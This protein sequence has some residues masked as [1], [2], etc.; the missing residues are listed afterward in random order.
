MSDTGSRTYVS[1]RYRLR[2]KRK[3]YQFLRQVAGANRYLWNAA[4][5]NIQKEYEEKGTSPISFYDLSKWYAEHKHTEASWLAEYPVRLMRPGLKGVSTAFKEFFK[6]TRQHPKFKKKGKARKSFAVNVSRGDQFKEGYFRLKRG[7]HVKMMAYDRLRR[8]SNPK[9]KTARIFEERGKWYMTVLYEVD[10]IERETDTV[11]IGVDRNVG[12]VADSTGDIHY[13]TRVSDARIKRL[14][15]RQSKQEQGSNR[16]RK[17]GK[18]IARHHKKAAHIRQNDLRHIAKHVSTTSTLIFL[19]DLK[20]KGLT[21]SGRGTVDKPGRNVR[22]KAGLNRAIL[23]T[24][25]GQLEQYLEERGVVHKV[26]P[27]YTSQ[28]CSECGHVDA[29]NRTSQ[30]GFTCLSCGHAMNADVNA[31]LNIRSS[32][33]ASV[34]GRGAYVRPVYRQRALKRQSE[35][36]Y[37]GYS[38]T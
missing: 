33:M 25:W 1:I 35:H 4:L 8:Y 14:Q 15:R 3:A 34:N 24:G 17:T 2:G 16:W 32:G 5:A 19:E 26:P 29:G 20:T 31:A 18:T 36:E 28:T 7:L 10:G 27:A 9:A 38:C 30:A 37:I 12:Q 6:G 11:G 22:Q 21:G 13:L 23:K